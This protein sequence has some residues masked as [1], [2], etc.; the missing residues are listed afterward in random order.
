MDVL[1]VLELVLD[2]LRRHAPDLTLEASRRLGTL[3][4]IGLALIAAIVVAR[5][6]RLTRRLR[7][8]LSVFSDHS[9]LPQA[10]PRGRRLGLVAVHGHEG[11]KC[12]DSFAEHRFPEQAPS[13]GSIQ[14]SV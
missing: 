3:A 11:E 4:G 1:I 5:G 14:I 7:G 2:D 6:C 9:S 10:R 12:G 13:E 8:S